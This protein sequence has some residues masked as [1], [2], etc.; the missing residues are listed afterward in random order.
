VQRNKEFTIG[1]RVRVIDFYHLGYIKGNDVEVGE[2]G[3]ISDGPHHL[4]RIE[5]PS[6]EVALD[7]GKVH[8]I[9]S[10]AIGFWEKDLELI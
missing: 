3:T 10:G 8:R 1:A 4:E 5:G 2:M 7:S 6:W 9:V